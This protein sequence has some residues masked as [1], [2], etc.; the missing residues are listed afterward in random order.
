MSPLPQ[1]R[2]LSHPVPSDNHPTL[3]N[4]ADSSRLWDLLRD[5]TVHTVLKKSALKELARRKDPALIEHCDV[6]LSSESR[7]DW[8]LGVSTLS[9]LATNEA[10]D[11]LISTFARSLGEDRIFVLE[12]VA[13]ILRADFVRPFSIMVREIARPGELNVSRWSRVAISTLREVCKRFGIE[14][15]YEDGVHTSHEAIE[16]LTLPVDP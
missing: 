4:D 6:L 13:S 11:R 1:L 10:V 7:S 15:V 3:H 9:V 5:A 8:C 12:C 16:D 14:T 2:L